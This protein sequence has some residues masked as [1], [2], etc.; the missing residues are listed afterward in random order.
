MTSSD[1]D[2]AARWAADGLKAHEARRP[3]DAAPSFSRYEIRGRLGEGVSGIV[4]RAWDRDLRREVALKVLHETAVLTDLGRERFRR[5]AQAAAGLSHPNVVAVFDAGEESGRLF[6]VMEIVDGRQLR[7]VL[8]DAAR[9]ESDAVRLVEGAARGLA[10]AH[11]RGIVHRDVKPANI[12]VTA[13]G[14]PKVADFGLAHLMDHELTRTGATLGTPQYMSPEQVRGKPRDISPA[15]DVYALGAVLY[16][17]LSG[18]PPHAGETLIELY[19]R[20]AGDEP[21]PP[22]RRNPRI[23]ADLETVILKSLQKDPRRRYPDAGAFADDLRRARENRPVDARPDSAAERLVRRFRRHR[24]AVA[25]ASALLLAAALLAALGVRSAR[26]RDAAV[27]TMRETARVSL[28]AA[29]Q[30]RRKGAAR[31]ELRPYLQTLQTTYDRA[32]AQAPDVAELDYLMGRMQRALLKDDRALGYQ[33]AALRKDPTYVP[34]LYERVILLSR[35]Y[36]LDVAR[37]SEVVPKY[38][39]EFAKEDRPPRFS[40]EE[41]YRRAREKAEREHPEIRPI[42]DAILA[43]LAKVLR[44]SDQGGAARALAARGIQAFH[45]GSYEEARKVLA[46]C[47]ALDPHLEEAWETLAAAIEARCREAK[48]P[49]EVDRA[50]RDVEDCATRALSH[51][52]GYVPHW[53]RLANARFHV[54][55]G[56]PAFEAAE[57]DLRE[58]LRLDPESGDAWHGRGV[59]F[60]NRFTEPDWVQA[61]VCFAE[62][63]RFRPESAEIWMWRGMACRYRAQALARRGEDPLPL[64]RE[65]ERHTDEAIRRSADFWTAW[66]NRGRIRLNRAV[67]RSDRGED[68]RPELREADEAFVRAFEL[69]PAGDLRLSRGDCSLRAARVSERLGQVARALDEYRA[70]A[71]HYRHA[72]ELAPELQPQVEPLVRESDAKVAELAPK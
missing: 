37:V 46:E 69:M 19:E 23:S 15:T 44:A 70:A 63:V 65:A 53:I 20:I 42:R 28:D 64:L 52:R 9:S 43:D 11:A 33:E 5:E 8:R 66:R 34:S 26:L 67:W 40:F 25:A 48:S 41:L 13:S 55:D 61:E 35:K 39:Q 29:L 59:L 72:I 10:A 1:V 17:A 30:L 47:V 27:E 2:D 4:Y 49:A 14:E 58:A 56:Q 18:G 31:D 36:G 7:D 12:L 60:T 45:L 22:R 32:V 21:V 3:A 24:A 57:R 16:E 54:A 38:G 6:C 51:D 68:S 71:G 62:A 50:L